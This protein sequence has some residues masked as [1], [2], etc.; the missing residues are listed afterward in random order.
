MQSSNGAVSVAAFVVTCY[1]PS[2]KVTT[3]NVVIVL[4]CVMLAGLLIIKR[5]Q[6]QTVLLFFGMIMMTAA[7][8]LT[9]WVNPKVESTGWWGFDLFAN[10]DATISKD[11]ADLGMQIMACTGFAK[12]MDYIGASSRMVHLALKPLAKLKRPYLIMAIIFLI[13]CAMSLVIPSASGLA[14]LMMVIAFPI[15]TSLGV[16]PLGAA[17]AVACGHLLDFGPAS[18]TSL[19]A[20]KTAKLP[21]AE[22]FTKYQL[23]VY[24]C[25]ALV[26]AVTMALWQRYLDRKEALAAGLEQNGTGV[27]TAPENMGPV[28]YVVLPFIPLALLLTFS[29]YG[30]KHI[31]IGVVVAMFVGL[32]IAMVCELIRKR[33]VKDVAASI[34]VFFKGM[35]DQ[36]ASTVTLIVA[37]EIFA[38]GITA[39]GVV[40]MLARV[41]KG[42]SIP[43]DVIMIGISLLIAVL[44]VVMGS[45]VAAMTAFAPLV[46]A[47]AKT[48]GLIPVTTLLCM[49]NAGSL[50]RLVSPISAVMI[51]VALVAEISP[52]ELVKRNSVPVAMAMITSMLAIVTIF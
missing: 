30:I 29:S 40:P 9:G 17:S 3:M 27:W 14:M 6:A 5:Y 42:A 37:G 48:V 22:Y 44:A 11:A 8:F 45:G 28:S 39:L 52:M 33:N 21:V 36:F 20:A 47:F 7:Y 2:L 16:S 32:F 35:G 19:L 25:C 1:A 41:L 51:A 43:A 10:V 12:Y 4:A 38:L 50:G 46:P 31:S 13:N 24:I 15:L 23:P 18:A 34:K 49:Q 26:A